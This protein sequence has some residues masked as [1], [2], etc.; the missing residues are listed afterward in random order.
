MSVVFTRSSVTHNMRPSMVLY[1]I[2]SRVHLELLFILHSN[3]YTHHSSQYFSSE[4]P[5]VLSYTLRDTNTHARLFTLQQVH[6]SIML[7]PR[8]LLYPNSYTAI[9]TPQPFRYTRVS[10]YYIR[11]NKYT[12]SVS[13][14]W[15]VCL[16]SGSQ[17]RYSAHAVQTREVVE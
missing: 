5:P 15:N 7:D 17:V 16:I 8:I 3:K 1:R 6:T 4:Y 9:C 14:W 13:W 12:V 2:L 10:K 11:T